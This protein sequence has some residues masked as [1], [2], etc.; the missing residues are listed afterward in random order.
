[1]TIFQWTAAPLLLGMAGSHA[2]KA[3]RKRD[4]RPQNLF[5]SLVWAS[6]GVLVLR[7]DLSMSL[8]HMVGIGRGADLALYLALIVG[9]FA[10]LAQYRRHRKLENMLTELVR[11]VAIQTSET[12]ARASS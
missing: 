5:W 3:L 8:A 4:R 1:M 2:W 11:H 6:A 10:T 9:L 7:P 12:G